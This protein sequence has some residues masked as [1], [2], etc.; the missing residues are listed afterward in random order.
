V[1]IGPEKEAR[2]FLAPILDLQ[3]ASATYTYVP[4]NKL[5]ATAGGAGFNDALCQKGPYR[6]FYTVNMRKLSASTFQATFDTMTKYYQAHPDALSSYINIETF[7][8]Q[9]TAAVPNSA[10]AYPWRDAIGFM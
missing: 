9:A 6:S 1:Y 3:P 5:L 2:Q 8:N 4:W 7:P 10:T